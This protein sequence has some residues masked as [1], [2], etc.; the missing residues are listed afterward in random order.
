DLVNSAA[1]SADG[2]RIV[3]GSDDRTARVWDAETGRQI[4]SVM[5]LPE[6]WASLDDKSA[7]RDHGPNFWRY[8]A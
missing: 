5:G 2:R 6:S 7:I 3:T 1:F 4:V 8:V